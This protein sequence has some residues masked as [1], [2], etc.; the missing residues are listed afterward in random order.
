MF[1]V[2]NSGKEEIEGDSIMRV[3]WF[4]NHFYS[5]YLLISAL[6]Y[7][8]PFARGLKNIGNTCFLNS[9][10][11]AISSCPPFIRFL[12]ELD[13]HRDIPFTLGLKNCLRGDELIRPKFTLPLPVRAIFYELF[14]TSIGLRV[15]GDTSYLT[16]WSETSKKPVDTSNIFEMIVSYNSNFNGHDQQVGNLIENRIIAMRVLMSQQKFVDSFAVCHLL[17]CRMH[18]SYSRQYLQWLQGI[19]REVEIDLS[20]GHYRL[21]IS[22]VRIPN[23]LSLRI[24]LRVG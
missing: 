18:K 4:M 9:V 23:G 11:Q 14:S 15:K 21:G 24:R 10:L 17:P 6:M 7:P 12:V 13:P 5:T 1:R 2:Q 8:G 20:I 16:S 19:Q 22:S 3:L